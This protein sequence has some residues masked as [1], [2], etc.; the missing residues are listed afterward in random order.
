[1]SQC[2]NQMAHF[3][4]LQSSKPTTKGKDIN[5][6]MSKHGTRSLEVEPYMQQNVI[7]KL[8]NHKA[9]LYDI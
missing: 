2:T 1:M 7:V 6:L 3:S 8:F 5:L 4:Q 9:L